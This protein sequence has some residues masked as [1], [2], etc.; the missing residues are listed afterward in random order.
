[1]SK[2]VGIHGEIKRKMQ[3]LVQN[4]KWGI[5]DHADLMEYAG[6]P[7][8]NLTARVGSLCYDSVGDDVYVNST[9]ADVW[10]KIFD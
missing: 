4:A 1:M 2:R 7:N 3:S 9:G 10:I 8:G 5:A 6:D